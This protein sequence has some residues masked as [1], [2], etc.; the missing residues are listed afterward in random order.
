MSSSSRRAATGVCVGSMVGW[1]SPDSCHISDKPV[2]PTNP[3][4]LPHYKAI[5]SHL[6]A[7]K[8]DDELPLIS[9]KQSFVPCEAG[10]SKAPVKPIHLI[11]RSSVTAAWAL[12]PEHYKG[13][14]SSSSCLLEAALGIVCLI[15]CLQ[16]R[17]EYL[18]SGGSR[19]AEVSNA[20]QKDMRIT[21]AETPAQPLPHA[22][23]AAGK[24]HTKPV[25]TGALHSSPCTVW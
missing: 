21:C 3:V 5:S 11:A 22:P 4:S 13:L 17:A 20:Q 24:A 2:P 15:G 9:L 12:A 23:R 18:M 14:P 8:T 7:R 6:T 10:D 25:P 1:E 16:H 19:K